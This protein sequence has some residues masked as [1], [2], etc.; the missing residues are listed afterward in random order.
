MVTTYVSEVDVW[1]FRGIA[2]QI[3]LAITVLAMKI[4]TGVFFKVL[5]LIVDVRRVLAQTVLV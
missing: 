5:L 4:L 2:G 1:V 3:A